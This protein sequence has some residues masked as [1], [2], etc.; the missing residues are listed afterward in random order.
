MY[1]YK[2]LHTAEFFKYGVCVC[3]CICV[4]SMYVWACGYSGFFVRACVWVWVWVWVCSICMYM[5]MCECVHVCW[6]T[7]TYCI[8][9]LRMY[10]YVWCCQIT[11]H[12]LQTVDINECRV[13][14]GGC[15]SNQLCDNTP[16]GFRCI[17]PPG[18]VLANDSVTCV[19]SGTY[20]CMCVQWRHWVC[21]WVR[22]WEGVHTCTV[23]TIFDLDS[24][25]L[26]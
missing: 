5:C 7:Y 19:S 22:V 13:S 16:G 18:T 23:W 26:S 8:F 3:A 21:V 9:R 4:H 17:C 2:Q 6:C 15:V 24:F 11:N 10:V 20:T 1:T 12:S 25:L 14:N